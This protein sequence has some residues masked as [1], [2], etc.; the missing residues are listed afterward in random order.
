MVG[1]STLKLHLTV[2]VNGST[3]FITLTFVGGTKSGLQMLLMF[4][5]KDTS[6]MFQFSWMYLLV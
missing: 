3:D 1:A 4:G 6:S 2:R 5:S